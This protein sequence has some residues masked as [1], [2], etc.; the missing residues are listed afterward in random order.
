SPQPHLDGHYT[1]FGKLISGFD[2]LDRITQGD[3]ITSVEAK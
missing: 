1:V 3:L 2:V